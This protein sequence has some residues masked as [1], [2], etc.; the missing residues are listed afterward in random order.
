MAI[1]EPFFQNIPAELKV[2]PQWVFWKS[3]IRDGK[4]TKI[5][6]CPQE[7]KRKAEADNPKTWG[8]FEKVLSTDGFAGIGYVFFS[9]DPYCGI[10]LD[11]CR[12][13]ESGDIEP[14]AGDIIKQLN[15]YSEIS[16]SGTGIH[17]IIKGKLPAGQRRKGKVEMYDSR[18]YFTMTGHCL[19]EL[20][21]TI[22]DRQ[23]ELE[24]LHGEIFGR[25]QAPPK[26]SRPHLELSDR[27]LIDKAH[28][29]R[30]GGKFA[31]LWRGEWQGD[32]PSQSEATAALLNALVFYCGDDPARVDR[33]F[34][35]SGL[36]RPKWDRP[37]TGSTWGAIEIQKAVSRAT[38]FYNPGQRPH[39]K[40]TSAQKAHSPVSQTDKKPVLTPISA[41]DLA[42]KTF[43]PP[44]WAIPDLFPEGIIIL[45]GK[46][47][48][49]KSWLALNMAVAVAAGG[50]ALGKIQVEAGG[51][52]YLALEDS[53]R[54]LQERQNKIIMFDS[55]FPENL[56]FLTAKDFPPLHKGGL[57]ALD[58]WLK[59]HPQTR[60]VIIDTL[61]RIK[62]PRSKSADAYDHDT[63][64]IA[65]LQ[66]LAINHR[67]ALMVVHHTKKAESDDFVEAV[68]GTFG[69]TGAADCI[70]V[71]IRKNRAAAD[72]VLKITGRDVADMEKALK[73]HSDLGVWEILG[74]AQ[75]FAS[76]QER[77]DILLILKEVGP[78]T[79]AQL[80]K[81]VDKSID[82]LRMALMRMKN[83]GEIRRNS[84]GEYCI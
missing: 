11:K 67:L 68:S 24:A 30:N 66:A 84:N 55:S 34:R 46:P 56:Y 73:F 77:Q 62:P 45:A 78:K 83:N 75:E 28:Q 27:E 69:L 57:D 19:P 37:Q 40:T 33:L 35:Q 65:A 7:P 12:N 15:S 49:G 8:A 36:M 81:L 71:L 29:A 3:E 16:P 59:E 39:P 17:I 41:K 43:N 6:Y 70:A 23:T 61:A 76:S 72:A 31:K 5:P 32:Y 64:I 22:E 58:D 42:A 60:L 9:N 13:P 18:R 47:K 25:P 14:W 63:A 82:A 2:L 20:P 26:D 51:V 38:E 4:P 1:L 53:E 21:L 48:T 50:I 80:S 52:L 54:R 79:P 74:E 10:D 44:R